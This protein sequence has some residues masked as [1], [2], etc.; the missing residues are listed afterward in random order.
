[1]S[2]KDTT[3]AAM[4]AGGFGATT[5]FGRVATG[6]VSVSVLLSALAYGGASLA[7]SAQV[8]WVQFAFEPVVIAACV[9][10]LMFAFGKLQWAP[11]IT[12]VCVAGTVLVATV[13]T[14]RG[15]LGQVQIAGKDQGLSLK[16]WLM[17]RVGA[18]AFLLMLAAA[19]V[20]HRDVAAKRFFV[21]GLIASVPFGA[22][23]GG[24]LFVLQKHSP[25][26][27]SMPG[28]MSVGLLVTLG[29]AA[30]VTLCMAGHCFMR[31]FEIGADVGEGRKVVTP[32]TDARSS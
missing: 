24:F 32:P 6:V 18:A 5:K 20:V 16:P 28:W 21:K 3:G 23:L 8:P 22:T 26:T 25:G 1:M 11:A 19:E 14:Y 27:S 10:G 12:L 29:I 7:L 9:V 13:L 31:A 17:G 2:S 15:M 30:G 4:A